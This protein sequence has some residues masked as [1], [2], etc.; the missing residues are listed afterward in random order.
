MPYS[1]ASPDAFLALGM[2]SA[3]GTAQVTAEKLR[4]LKYAAGNNIEVIPDVAELREGGDGLDFGY[5]YKKSVKG[6]GQLVGNIRPDFAGQL[7]QLLPGGATWDGASLP[8]IHT[9]HTGHASHPWSTIVAR[10]PGD[11]ISHLFRDVRLTGLTIE[12]AA[13]EPWKFTA[14]L[15]ALQPGASLGSFTPS[16]R[17]QDDD[18]PFVFHFQPTYAIDGTADTDITGFKI[19]LALGVEE[20]LAQAITLDEAVVQNRAIDV[21]ITR[22]FEDATLWKKIAHGGGVSPTTSVPTGAFRAAARFNSGASLRE[23][24]L[25]VPLLSYRQNALTELDPDGR[26][27]METISGRA[28][29]GATHALV[30]TLKNSHASGYAS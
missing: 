24:I 16:Y 15:I 10:H 29:K 20:L 18:Q 30:I 3:L 23:L 28:L 6:A 27:V 13:G 26:T 25:D 11:A 7:F 22:R 12:G 8:A 1:S 4:F 5:V 9:F 19:D 14:P 21:E 17:N 2:Q